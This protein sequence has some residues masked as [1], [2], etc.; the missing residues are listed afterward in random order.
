MS[1]PYGLLGL[2]QYRDRTGY[3]LAK[4]FEASLNFFWHAQSSQIYR[5]LN[6][7]EEKGWVTS[8]SVI[9]EGKPN[10]RVYSITDDGL[11]VFIKYMNDPGPM[12]E[13]YHDPFLMHVFFGASAPE[14]VLERFKIFRKGCIYGL[15]VKIKENQERINAY[16]F[17]SPN[18]EKESLFW[19]MTH[20]FGTF[21]AKAY[22]QWAEECIEKLEAELKNET[23]TTVGDELS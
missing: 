14:V 3:D 13:T 22:L 19:Q 2:L 4:L 20:D 6:R 8:K 21:Q 15:E 10:K 17:L 9:Q 18:G 7:M 16:K 11:N 23:N 5:E 1:L 12:Y